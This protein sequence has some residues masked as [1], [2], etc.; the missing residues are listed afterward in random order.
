MVT[1]WRKVDTQ[2][3]CVSAIIYIGGSCVLS[4]SVLLLLGLLQGPLTVPF[5]H[6]TRSGYNTFIML[7]YASSKQTHL[8]LVVQFSLVECLTSVPL[9]EKARRFLW[10]F[11]III[12]TSKPMFSY[13]NTL[14]THFLTTLCYLFHSVVRFQ[15]VILVVHPW[16]CRCSFVKASVVMA[17][18]SGI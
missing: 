11:H 6:A 17:P 2:R 4:C 14:L 12:E 15:R 8:P 13:N 9:N 18:T 5:Q 7:L 3:T 1:L 16:R 10:S